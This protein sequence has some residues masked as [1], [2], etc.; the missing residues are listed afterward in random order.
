MD[1]C[2]WWLGLFSVSASSRYVKACSLLF[3]YIVL[4]LFWSV[5]FLFFVALITTTKT[6]MTMIMIILFSFNYITTTIIIV[7]VL[8]IIAS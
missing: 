7:T 5:A 2:L 1:C 8:V 4:L 6:T 3:S